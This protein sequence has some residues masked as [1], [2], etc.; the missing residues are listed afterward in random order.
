MLDIIL[1]IV[2]L[3]LALAFLFLAVQFRNLREDSRAALDE[4]GK[5]QTL[6]QEKKL[7]D[8]QEIADLRKKL[9]DSY[10]SLRL[11]LGEPV[12]NHHQPSEPDKEEGT[13]A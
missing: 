1:T 5:A 6:F 2:L 8:A 4:Y 10:L 9:D 7:D 12:A 13:E 11:A 3:L